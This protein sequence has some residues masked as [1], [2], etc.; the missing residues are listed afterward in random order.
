[1][2]VNN[3]ARDDRHRLEDV[4]PAYW[5][6]TVLARELGERNIRVNAIVPGA[7]FTPR[8]RKRSVT[9]EGVRH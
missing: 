3:A 9:S 5:D 1:M 4:T 7:E 6:D 2:L 8:A